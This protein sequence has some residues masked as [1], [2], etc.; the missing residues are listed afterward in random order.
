MSDLENRIE[1]LEGSLGGQGTM[2][3]PVET[4]AVISKLGLDPDAVRATAHSRQES[5][6]SVIAG[7]LSMSKKEFMEAVKKAVKRGARG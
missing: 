6:A 1:R 7:E 2:R 5:L 4:D 3:E